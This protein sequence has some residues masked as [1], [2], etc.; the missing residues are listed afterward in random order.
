MLRVLISRRWLGALAAAV[1]FAVAAFFLGQWQWHR[2]EA[3]AARADRIN[4]HYSAKPQPL[5]D[6]LG[7]A[8]MALSKEWTRVTATGTYAVDR[9]LLVRNRPYKGTYGYE[10]L[11]PLTLQGGSTVLVDR[12]W[13]VNAETA[14]AAPAVPAAPTQPVTVTGWLRRSEPSLG[15]SLPKGQL[16][17]INLGEASRQ[18]GSPVLG[19]YVVLEVERLSDG[20]APARPTALEAPDTDLGPH[21]A[22]AFQWWMGM[23]GGFV[24]VW[25]G[26]RREY[27]DGLPE[28]V[29]A[30]AGAKAPKPKRTRIWDEEDG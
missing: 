27:R 19:A 20:S 4:S 3:K 21:Q 30:P 15:K 12:G 26:A 23:V 6:V 16:A 14:E 1:G 11:V 25:F 17:S 5:A 8:P 18:V 28:P 29:E 24:L 9:T 7:T 13:V 10:V 22:Y 2:Y